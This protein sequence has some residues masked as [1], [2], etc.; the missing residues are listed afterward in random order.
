[1]AFLVVA[2]VVVATL[3]LYLAILATWA[4]AHDP[5]L[6]KAGRIS[7]ILASWLLPI[8]AAVSI[9][10]SVAEL[11]PASMPAKR[12]LAP[13]QWLLHVPPRRPNTLADESDSAGYGN[14]G[15]HESGH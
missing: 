2:L 5:T 6:P 4:V 3:A 12:F 7:R 9:L 8:G 10:R 13:V 14:P 15:R 1:M 11:A